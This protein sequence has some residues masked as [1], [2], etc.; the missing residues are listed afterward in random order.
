MLV[1]KYCWSE[2]RL[3]IPR[4]IKYNSKKKER[5]FVKMHRIAAFQ[6]DILRDKIDFKMKHPLEKSRLAYSEYNTSWR[7]IYNFLTF[8]SNTF[9]RIGNIDNVTF[10]GWKVEYRARQLRQHKPQNKNIHPK[11][12]IR[13]CVYF[14]FVTR[15]LSGHKIYTHADFLKLILKRSSI[16]PVPSG[17]LR[18]LKFYS[19][20][21]FILVTRSG[22]FLLIRFFFI[23]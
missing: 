13:Q 4:G 21:C 14:P 12:Y 1:W 5:L 17:N 9:L 16:Y 22:F 19:I 11:E 7:E 20:K 6:N 8:I 23:F 3:E 18:H 2:N 10:H 15:Q